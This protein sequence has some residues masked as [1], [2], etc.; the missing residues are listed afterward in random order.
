MSQRMLIL[1]AVFACAALYGCNRSDSAQTQ[2][3]V[4]RA[5]AEAEKVVADAQARYDKITAESK[6]EVAQ[7]RA[8]AAAQNAPAP[9]PEPPAK[10]GAKPA[11]GKAAADSVADIAAPPPAEPQV[12]SEDLARA[13]AA[14]IRKTAEAKF[15]LD[16]ARAEANYKVALAHC[17]S[18]S[19]LGEKSC[20][21][22][23]KEVYDTELATLKARHS[24]G[25]QRG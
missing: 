5:Q 15:E 22:T 13:R 12:D 21:K 6:Q 3:D 24:G 8:E 7:A 10:P 17:A 4:A 20:K 18:Q 1:S 16:K 14:Q 9:A 25:P 23:A 11:R 19:A 2:A